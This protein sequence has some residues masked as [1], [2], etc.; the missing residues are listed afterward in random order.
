MHW[1]KV[2]DSRSSRRSPQSGAAKPRSRKPPMTICIAAV[3][4]T[5][6]GYQ[7][8]LCAADRKIT[9]G[10][11]EY[12][13]NFPNKFFLISNSIILMPSGDYS[14]HAA[15]VGD[16]QEEMRAFHKAN[17]GVWPNV[18]N[19]AD[20]YRA[21]Y[22][23]RKRRRWEQETLF[24]E[25]LSLETFH[26]SN[27][28][29]E[30]KARLIKGIRDDLLPPVS[31]IIAGIDEGGAHIW[32]TSDDD[33]PQPQM[34]LGYAA[35]GM[36]SHHAETQYRLA[37]YSPYTNPNDALWMIY[38]AKKRSEVAPSVGSKATDI[39]VLGPS[40][41]SHSSIP[42]E[43]IGF[44]NKGFKSIERAERRAHDNVKGKLGAFISR[45]NAALA[46]AAEPSIPMREARAKL[47]ASDREE[48]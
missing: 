46:K 37:R 14:L 27:L 7:F 29:E 23:N 28:S 15:M 6:E 8:V 19:F 1:T 10:D 9:I 17:P 5:T 18:E 13:P 38:L 33:D 25:G 47:P 20:R 34:P 24:P 39:Y 21:I 4:T 12:E 48:V 16:L 26:T 30:T 22:A 35:V 44:L 40:L 41:G 42:E 43:H 11:T 31:A 3:A 36:G 45:A 32:T 2:C